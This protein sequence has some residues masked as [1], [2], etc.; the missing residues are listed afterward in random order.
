MSNTLSRKRYSSM[1][2]AVRYFFTRIFP[3]I[4]LV[5]MCIIFILP[6]YWMLISAVKA[7]SELL[8][9]PPTLFPKEFHFENYVQAI[10]YIPFFRY[11]F[12]TLVIA[13]FAVIGAMV[14]NSLVSYGLSRINWKGRDVLFYLV[15]ATMFI[16]FPVTMI[17]LFDIFAKVHLINTYVPLT[18]PYYV[19]SA[20]Q[21]FMMRQYLM[22]IPKEIS[23]AG[24]IDGANEF[25]IFV[26]LILPIMRP[27]IAVV[28]IFTAVASWNDFLTPLIYL[29]QEDIYPISIG[30]QLFRS[31]HGLEYQLLMAASSMVALPVVVIFLCF[32]KFFVEGITIGAVKG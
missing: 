19:G 4:V 15:I 29:H 24:I 32:Q 1:A 28:A 8:S 16:P 23:D 14:S 7:P 9:I 18:L 3:R 30:L 20:T 6:F 12:N 2:Y 26:R 11:M 31:E 13:T 17:A 25:Q 22:G 10:N 21:I 5:F 27:V